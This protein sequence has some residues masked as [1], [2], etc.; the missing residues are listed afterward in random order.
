MKKLFFAFLFFLVPSFCFSYQITEDASRDGK[1]I[2]KGVC[3]NNDYFTVVEKDRFAV[4]MACTA[5]WSG[6]TFKEC[7]TG[8]RHNED[9]WDPSN[10]KIPTNKAIRKV[11]GE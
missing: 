7:K 3:S 11:C 1:H 5:W 4:A 8:G 6:S 10:T 2:V 9:T